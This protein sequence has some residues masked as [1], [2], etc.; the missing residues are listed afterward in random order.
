MTK[1]SK[2]AQ[3]PRNTVGSMSDAWINTLFLYEK[4]NDSGN[5]DFWLNMTGYLHLHQKFKSIK[6]HSNQ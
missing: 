4:K 2:G 3:N 6:C 1:M 5:F